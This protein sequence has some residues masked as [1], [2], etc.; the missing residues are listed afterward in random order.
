MISAKTL[1]Q[2]KDNDGMTLKNGKE[3]NYKTGYQVATDGIETKSAK[4]AAKAIKFYNGTCG[5]WYAGGIY[6]IDKSKRVKTKKEA[7]EIGRKHN[8]ISVLN[9]NNMKLIYC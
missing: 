8:Q 4:E 5:I 6:Y 2:L 9:W 7:L 1:K 3:I